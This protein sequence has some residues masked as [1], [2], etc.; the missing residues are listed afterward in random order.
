MTTTNKVGRPPK[1]MVDTAIYNKE[2]AE[3]LRFFRQKYISDTAAEAAE[4][5]GIPQSTLSHL[6]NGNRGI[7]MNFIL[8]YIDKYDLNTKWLASGEGSHKLKEVEATGG[9]LAKTQN[10]LLK[11]L[12]KL[13]HYIALMEANQAHFMKAVEKRSA[14]I[15]QMQDFMHNYKK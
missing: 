15:E 14:V 1:K 13:E 5:L 2:V 9:Q 6:E 4:L 11:R 3:R 7:R 12:A 8:L 10:E